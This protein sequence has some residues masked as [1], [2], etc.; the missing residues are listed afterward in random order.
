MWPTTSGTGSVLD[1]G[2]LNRFV[3]TSLLLNPPSGGSPDLPCWSLSTD[4]LFSLKSAY[5]VA[6]EEPMDSSIQDPIFDSIWKWDGPKRYQAFLWKVAHERLLTNAERVRR[7]MA[8]EDVC[9]RCGN[10]PETDMR[11]LRDCEEIQEFW[12]RVVHPDHISRFL[13]VGLDGWLSFNLG[14][15]NVGQ[16]EVDWRLFFGVAIYDLWRDRNRLVFNNL[17]SLGLD[18]HRYI[19]NEAKFISHS[20][21]SQ[22]VLQGHP[23]RNLINVRWIPPSEGCF[24]V[25]T[26]G[27]HS[28]LGISSYG[29]LIRNSQ[30]AMINGF[31]C[32]LGSGNALWA[33]LWGL[34][35][36]IK[37]AQQ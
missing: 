17:S 10:C 5:G 33:E 12:R 31:Y 7:H 26:D 6:A 16:V 19:V 1:D 37:L 8:L 22:H 25:N 18:L 14:S 2:S 4:G 30:G 29:G 35:F 11:V 9:P 32:K 21:A 13:S 27:S 28:R 23:P 3:T 20:L 15:S 34:W 36:G 24:K